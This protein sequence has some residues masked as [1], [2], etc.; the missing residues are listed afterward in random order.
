MLREKWPKGFLW[1]QGSGDTY[2]CEDERHRKTLYVILLA[3]CTCA[4]IVFFRKCFSLQHPVLCCWSHSYLQHMELLQHEKG[5]NIVVQCFLILLSCSLSCPHP[6]KL[7]PSC[8]VIQFGSVF[9]SLT[10]YTSQHRSFTEFSYKDL[11]A[12]LFHSLE[13]QFQWREGIINQHAISAGCHES[14]VAGH[15]PERLHKFWL[16]F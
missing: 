10:G 5:W 9:I 11:S 2:I 3:H 13:V 8:K 6:Q 16:I 1:P 4:G 15:P 7:L 12:L 14:Q